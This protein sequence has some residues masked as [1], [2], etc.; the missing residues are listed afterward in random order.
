MNVYR[1]SRLLYLKSKQLQ[2]KMS[3]PSATNPTP[4]RSAP[5]RPLLEPK[6][7]AFIERLAT[8]RIPPAHAVSF[9]DAHRILTLLQSGPVAELPCLVEDRTLPV[10]PTGAIGVRIVRPKD[11]QELLPAVLYFHGG[12]WVMG[13]KESHDRLVHELANGAQAAVVF[14]DYTLAPLAQYPVQNEQAYAVL[15]YV[16]ENPDSLNIDAWRIAV[17]GDCAGGNM[18][19]AVT[20]LAKERRGPSIVFQLLFCPVVSDVID[21]GDYTTFE[22]DPWLTKSAVHGYLDAFFPDSASRQQITAFPLKASLEQLND[23]PDALIIVA[24]NDVLRDQGEAYARKLIRAGV[25]VTS[26][27]YNNTIHDFVVLNALAD[28]GAARGAVAQ[29]SAAL[30]TVFYAE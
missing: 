11:A 8:S 2:A 30:R 15:K 28:S 22:D 27:R 21:T 12:G 18:A 25:T 10:G 4:G 24:E 29:A 20:L 16:A 3:H 5:T 23:L 26:T 7:Q 17:A 1:L 14:V 6:A 19:A 9:A 13:G